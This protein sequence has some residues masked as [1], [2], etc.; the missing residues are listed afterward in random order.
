MAAPLRLNWCATCGGGRNFG[1]QLGPILLRHYGIP[2][3]WASPATAE[4][5]AVGSILSKVPN[6]WTGTV[7]GT[8]FIRAGMHK[9]LSRARVLAVR[10][11]L[12]RKAC[13]L[14]A[15]VPLGDL[16][17]LVS[18][19]PRFAMLPTG[20]LVIP[21]YVDHDIAAR[22]PGATVVPV[23]SDPARIL[24]AIAAARIVYTSSLHALIAADTLGVPHVVEPHPLVLGGMF[25]FND[26]ASA[27]GAKIRPGIE[28]LTPRAAL[29]DRQQ[30]L[31]RLVRTLQR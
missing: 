20:P 3:V 15:S 4:I 29:V 12:T 10:G 25:K 27:F 28:R 22:H 26:Y 24:S 7:L 1:D 21:H 18:D 5:I 16:G 8:G 2:V 13:G 11:A 9:D 6:G 30:E 23:T 19:L 31:R 17:L 14:P